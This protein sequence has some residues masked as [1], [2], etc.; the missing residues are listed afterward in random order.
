MDSRS[1]ND[2]FYG[3]ELFGFNVINCRPGFAYVTY[4]NNVTHGVCV[5]AGRITFYSYFNSVMRR[6]CIKRTRRS[7]VSMLI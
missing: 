5:N 3:Y 4:F 6:V 2:N 1:S 7:S